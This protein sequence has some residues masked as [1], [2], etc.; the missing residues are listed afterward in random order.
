MFLAFNKRFFDRI[1]KKKI[2]NLRWFFLKFAWEKCG[3][4][5]AG[6]FLQIRT[7]I[8]R[9]SEKVLPY[10][11]EVP[12]AKSER[13]LRDQIYLSQSRPKYDSASVIAAVL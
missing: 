7:H 2:E 6:V 4:N 9:S 8:R 3:D 1:L 12:L 13:E 11:V 10:E 5:S